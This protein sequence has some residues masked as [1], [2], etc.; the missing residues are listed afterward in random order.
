MP[1]W[2]F[3]AVTVR[4]GFYGEK[5]KHRGEQREKKRNTNHVIYQM[6]HQ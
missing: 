5:V 6:I 2:L 4:H 1:T 3:T